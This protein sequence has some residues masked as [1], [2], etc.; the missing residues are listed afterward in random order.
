MQQH[1]RP[2]PHH[3]HL[4][5]LPEVAELSADH[6]HPANERLGRRIVATTERSARLGSPPWNAG[7]MA[8]RFSL[9]TLIT[10]GEVVV[11]TTA[12]VAAMIGVQGW[13]V[14]AVAIVASR[15]VAGVIEVIGHELVGYRHTMRALR[16]A[17]IYVRAC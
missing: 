3:G 1:L 4:V 5:S 15:L 13:S 12:A 10:L 6:A 14:A 16:R 7:P 17:R 8:E 9:L 2:G 11:A